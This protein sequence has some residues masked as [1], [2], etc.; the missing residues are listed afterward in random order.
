MKITIRTIPHVLICL[1][2]SKFAQFERILLGVSFW[3]KAGDSCI[4]GH[5]V[6]S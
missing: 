1:F 2:N 5:T 6:E 3:D 4:A